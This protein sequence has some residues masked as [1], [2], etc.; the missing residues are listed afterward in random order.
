[1][2]LAP[3]HTQLGEEAHRNRQHNRMNVLALLRTLDL[4]LQRY[5]DYC[6]IRNGM[7]AVAH[8]I[9]RMLGWVGRSHAEMG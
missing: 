2:A 9:S 3:R 1:M 6:L 5:N 8:F 7:M 4:N